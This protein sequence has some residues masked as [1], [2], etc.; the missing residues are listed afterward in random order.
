MKPTL[1]STFNPHSVPS[2]FGSKTQSRKKSD[3]KAISNSSYFPKQPS[4]CKGSIQK[5]EGGRPAKSQ[6]F[7]CLTKVLKAQV[8]HGG[9]V[10]NEYSVRLTPAVGGVLSNKEKILGAI[11]KTSE[12]SE[13]KILIV[14]YSP[15]GGGHTNRTLDIVRMAVER[16]SIP[17]N[18][19]VILHLPPKWLNTNRPESLTA[20]STLLLKNGISVIAAESDKPVYGYLLESTGGSNDSKILERMAS[21]P[22]RNHEHPPEILASKGRNVTNILECELLSPSGE[23]SELPVISAKNLMLTLSSQVGESSLKNQV[24]ILTDMDPALQKAAHM[25]PGNHRLDQQNHAIMLNH[26]DE[27][28]NL[29]P[30]NAFLAKVLSGAGEK[31]SHISLGDKNTLHSLSKM[32]KQLGITGGTKKTDAKNIVFREIFEKAESLT[33]V[34]QRINASVRGKTPFVGIVKSDAVRAPEDVNSLIYVYAHKKT[35]LIAQR[36]V[37][38]IKDGSPE[39]AGKLFLFCGNGAV[40]PYNSLHLAYIAD[41]H[42]ITT[43]G[44]GTTG[45]FSY[46]HKRTD[47]NSRLLVLPIEGHN[48]QEANADFLSSDDSTKDFTVRLSKDMDLSENIDRFVSGCKKQVPDSMSMNDFIGAVEDK[49]SYVKQGHDILFGSVPGFE[50]IERKEQLMHESTLLKATRAYTKI[51]FQ[52]IGCVEAESS[53]KV[54]LKENGDRNYYFPSAEIFSEFMNSDE[55]LAKAIGMDKA[56]IGSM[57]LLD[58]VRSYFRQLPSLNLTESV[59]KGAKLKEEIGGFFVTGF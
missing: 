35:N 58:E 44:A 5:L 43:A 50:S 1:I 42:G 4:K 39:Y 59:E 8:V 51:I 32:A 17:Q 25:V 24:F 55:K 6:L 40:G 14:G 9:L 3:I 23:F 49:D 2:T 57:P 47:S 30:K 19:T 20:L 26:N 11:R 46:L 53:I 45:E 18:S 7:S 33:V 13:A 37:Q 12:S 48:E 36:V 54:Q 34:S 56:K 29:T 10:S 41:A 28:S 38:A 27:E 21:Y 31:I 52:A 15:T 22:L 16:G